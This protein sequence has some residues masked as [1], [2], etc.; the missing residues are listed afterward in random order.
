MERIKSFKQHINESSPNDNDYLAPIPIVVKGDKEVAELAK[1]VIGDGKEPNQFFVTVSNDFMFN[2]DDDVT[3]YSASP[4]KSP[5]KLED[6][7]EVET[8]GPYSSAKDALKKANEI[9][10]SED[11]GPRYV[12]IEDRKSGQVYEKFLKAQQKVVWTE[13]VNDDLKQYGY[14]VK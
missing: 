11:A 9:D 1:K 8:F 10:L 6:K 12:M 5:I 2:M 3:S 14:D 13:E 4:K 7:V